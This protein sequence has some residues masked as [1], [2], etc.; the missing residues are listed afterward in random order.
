[1]F[2]KKTEKKRKGKVKRR[3]EEKNFICE[4]FDS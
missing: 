1:M 4:K 3:K 2:S